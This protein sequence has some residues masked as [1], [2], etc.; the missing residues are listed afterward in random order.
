KGQFEAS[1]TNISTLSQTKR[2]DNFRF[3]L[4]SHG[5][6]TESSHL[7]RNCRPESERTTSNYIYT[8]QQLNQ[9]DPLKSRTCRRVIKGP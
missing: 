5:S 3:P 2:T 8:P 6:S 1:E 7:D 4:K 9:T